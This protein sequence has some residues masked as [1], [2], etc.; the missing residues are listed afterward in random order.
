[1][2]LAASALTPLNR[3]SN[4]NRWSQVSSRASHSFNVSLLFEKRGI[5]FR[6]G[7][8]AAAAASSSPSPVNEDISQKEIPQRIYTWPD[9]KKPRVC[10]LG[11]GFGGLYTALRLESLIWA[12]DKKPQVL[13]VDQSERFVFKP[14][15]Y[16]LLS[17]EVDAWEIAPRFSELLANTGIQFFQDRV[18]MLHP[19]DHLGMNGST[20]SCSGGTVV[21]ESGL[22]VE[23]DCQVGSCFGV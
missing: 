19:A 21:L 7:I 20:G 4:A 23:Y 2:A 11:G 14:M 6:N 5:G 22:L 1:M 17:G 13:L 15:L 18:K 3:I 10:I 8:A 16:E 12:D 9:N